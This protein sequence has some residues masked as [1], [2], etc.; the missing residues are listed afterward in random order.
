MKKVFLAAV[1]AIAPVSFALAGAPDKEQPP[2][3][4]MD[5]ATPEMKNPGGTK[6]LLPA[7]KAMD[8]ATPEKKTDA[9]TATTPPA[10]ST[11]AATP[12]ASPALA[13]A[14]TDFRSSKLVGT[15]VYNAADENIGEIADVIIGSNGSVTAVVIGVGGF[16]GLGEKNVAMPFNAIKVNRAEN[17]TI[18]IVVDGTKE[19]LQSMPDFTYLKP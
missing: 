15:T 10:A 16:L 5:S 3:K 11:Q 8:E 4:A 2:A 12:A 7:Q 6:D 18:K 1:I 19:S 14:P 9:G 13:Q 17:N